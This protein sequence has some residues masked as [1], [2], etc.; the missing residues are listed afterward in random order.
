VVENVTLTE[1]ER[2]LGELRAAAGEPDELP[3]LRTSVMTH[4]AWV[5]ERWVEA[6]T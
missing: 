2:Q 3:R 6:A 4:M 1:V 5:P